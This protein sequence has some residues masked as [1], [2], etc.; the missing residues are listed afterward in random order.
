[1][2]PLWHRHAGQWSPG[3]G[4]GPDRWAVAVDGASPL[5]HGFLRAE[6]DEGASLGDALARLR[7]S[8]VPV[9]AVT[10]VTRSNQRSLEA[11]GATVRD[12]DAWVLTFPEVHGPRADALG[13]R[14]AMAL[15][16]ALRAASRWGARAFL[17]GAPLCLVGPH[18]HRVLAEPG[19]SFAESCA[20]CAARPTCPGVDARY[21]DRFVGD[22]LRPRPVSPV[23]P[24]AGEL[25]PEALRRTC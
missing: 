17:H 11:I 12:A 6:D 3:A 7:R 25:L 20:A 15:P 13:P 9:T 8:A 4:D 10:R 24:E 2:E 1:L 18:A 22:E 23:G 5:E 19:R 14:L 16:W 21:R